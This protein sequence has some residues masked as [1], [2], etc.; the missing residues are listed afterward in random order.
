MIPRHSTPSDLA[1]VSACAH[2]PDQLLPYVRAMGQVQTTLVG[3]YLVHTHGQ[4]AILVGYNIRDIHETQGIEDAVA[5]VLTWSHMERITVI[6][7][8]RPQL[9]P[10]H[11]VST[12]DAYYC[13]PL[14]VHVEKHANAR[15]M[16]RRATLSSGLRI[17]QH[18]HN[19]H[20]AHD[21]SQ[22]QAW[23]SAHQELMLHYVGRPDMALDTKLLFQRI[24][25]YCHHV[26]EAHIFSAYDANGALLAFTIADFTSLHTA[27]YMFSMRWPHAP[28]GVADA[29]LYSL[30]R[31]AHARGYAQCN[32][33]LG[34]NKGITF[35]KKKWGAVPSIPYVQTAWEPDR[36]NRQHAART[37][38]E[39][40][41][42]TKKTWLHGL[43]ARWR[44]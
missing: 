28:A 27:F 10:A 40:D 4:H 17:V 33:G 9:A 26:D 19:W 34:I 2:T 39:L 25:T 31:E 15:T 21:A 3:S 38:Q 30:L 8:V 7:P 18:S 24:G 43:F 32:L 44:P 22:G 23:T 16:C 14:P 13:V 1:A 35:F 5:H 20:S 29:L 6:A 36:Q 42:A 37:P 11:A 41:G 12:N